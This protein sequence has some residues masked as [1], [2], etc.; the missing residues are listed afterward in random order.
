MTE[1]P[2]MFDESELGPR[3]GPRRGHVATP[4]SG[5]PGKTCRSC[6]NYSVVGYRAKKHRKCG[7]AQAAWTH[8]PATDIRAGDPACHY[9]T[10]TT[11]VET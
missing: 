3:M 2:L 5:P 9:W 1:L 4:G 7:L 10:R 8:G 6:V 11:G